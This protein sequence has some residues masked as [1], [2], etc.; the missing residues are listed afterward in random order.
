MNSVI[1]R[2]Q[3]LSRFSLATPIVDDTGSHLSSSIN[4]PTSDKSEI[5]SLEQQIQQ[6]Q[7]KRNE[8]LTGVVP[9]MTSV[10][11]KG[12]CEMG[13]NEKGLVVKYLKKLTKAYK[14]NNKQ[15]LIIY[16]NVGILVVGLLNI[17]IQLSKRPPAYYQIPYMNNTKFES[18]VIPLSEVRKNWIPKES[19]AELLN[20]LPVREV[21]I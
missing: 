7:I 5:E 2:G 15:D 8:L 9:R 11:G 1:G 20:S 19:L 14:K 13:E 12:E 6:L 18:Q 17:V 21:K 16:L 4:P 3:A 10:E